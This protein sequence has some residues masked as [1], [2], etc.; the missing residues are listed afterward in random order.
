MQLQTAAE[1]A[2]RHSESDRQ[3]VEDPVQ[4]ARPRCQLALGDRKA[5]R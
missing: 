1:N 5:K 4:S 3:A 2:D